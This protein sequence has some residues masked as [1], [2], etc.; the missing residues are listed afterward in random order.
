MSGGRKGT[1]RNAWEI[2]KTC[3]FDMN[4]KKYE[5][6]YVVSGR[7]REGRKC[8]LGER[9]SLKDLSGTVKEARK[10]GLGQYWLEITIRYFVNGDLFRTDYWTNSDGTRKGGSVKWVSGYDWMYARGYKTYKPTKK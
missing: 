9:K 10:L 1:T 8:A 7:D 5:Y 6:T 4:D 2:S 3:V